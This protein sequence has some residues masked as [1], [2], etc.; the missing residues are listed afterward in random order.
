MYKKIILIFLFIPVLCFATDYQKKTKHK[1]K[2]KIY[3]QTD[4]ILEYINGGKKYL[5][6]ASSALTT[7]LNASN[8][9]RYNKDILIFIVNENYIE[10]KYTWYIPE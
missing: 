2:H 4:D 8:L 1:V 7:I 5:P 6:I 10:I 9:F 3:E